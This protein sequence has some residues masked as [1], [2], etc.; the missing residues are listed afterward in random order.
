MEKAKAKKKGTK[1][2]GKILSKKEWLAQF[3]GKFPY[4]GDGLEYQ[5]KIRKEWAK[6][7]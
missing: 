1:K 5:K 3:F 6:E 4:F 7:V 2:A